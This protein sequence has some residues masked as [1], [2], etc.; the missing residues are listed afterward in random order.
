VVP[1]AETRGFSAERL[2]QQLEVVHINFFVLPA[3]WSMLPVAASPCARVGCS[4]RFAGPP[5]G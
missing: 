4:R 1:D 2:R 5:D 3:A